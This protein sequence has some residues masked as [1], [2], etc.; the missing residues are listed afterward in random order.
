MARRQPRGGRALLMLLWCLVVLAACGFSDLF[1][2]GGAPPG[3]AHT[4]ISPTSAPGEPATP[5]EDWHTYTFP[6]YGFRVDVPAVLTPH[7]AILINGG[8]GEAISWYYEQA[9]LGSALRQAAADSSV[10]IQYSTTIT[11][12]NICPLRGVPITIGGGV[13]ARQETNIPLAGSGP[14]PAVPYVRVSLVAG[15]VAVRIQMA[16]T[17]PADTFL[18]RYGAIWQRLL[19]T[20]ATFPAQPPLGATHPCG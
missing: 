7:H 4:P 5:L 14:L 19:A 15:G 18:A 3:G 2:S 16:G 11:D 12:T 10:L 13:A 1:A 9:P 17:A 6:T 8:S 20:F